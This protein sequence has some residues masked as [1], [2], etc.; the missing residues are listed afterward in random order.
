MGD[1]VLGCASVDPLLRWALLTITGLGAFPARAQDTTA[2]LTAEHAQLESPGLQYVEKRS[3]KVNG[4]I[5]REGGLLV[6]RAATNGP[7]VNMTRVR[8]GVSGVMIEPSDIILKINGRRIDSLETLDAMLAETTGSVTVTVWDHNSRTADDYT[9]SPQIE[10]VVAENSVVAYS[11][12]GPRAAVQNRLYVLLVDLVKDPGDPLAH[13]VDTTLANVESALRSEVEPSRLVLAGHLADAECS[14]DKILSAIDTL[15]A[16]RRDSILVYICGH[17]G[18]DVRFAAEDPAG[19]HFFNIDG[20]D[21]L[22]RT[23]WDH[24]RS[25]RAKFRALI[26]DTCNVPQSIQTDRLYRAIRNL[27]PQ[28][29]ATACE[30][31][32]L[33]HRGNLDLSASKRDEYSW[34]SSDTGGWFSSEFAER[35]HDT[36]SRFWTP[37]LVELQRET[38]SYFVSRKQSIASDGSMPAATRSRLQDQAAL[39]PTVFRAELEQDQAPP[40]TAQDRAPPTDPG[41]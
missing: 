34:Y 5:R 22:R 17:G 8:D 38:N 27:P 32:F 36:P 2:Q 35:L 21:L 19:G 9:A 7:L 23:V 4:S 37:F 24:L 16:G 25:R 6:F 13:M 41:F 15:N 14:A 10:R 1:R 3:L 18:Y 39:T 28:G 30:W 29:E 12:G 31:L 20:G 33:G 26:S 11:S 40:L